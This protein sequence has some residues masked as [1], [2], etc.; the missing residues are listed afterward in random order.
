MTKGWKYESARHSLARR[1]IKSGKRKKAKLIFPQEKKEKLV[2]EFC[3]DFY[4][5][6][7]SVERA[8]NESP[9]AVIDDNLGK[10]KDEIQQI[11]EID[12]DAAI[13]SLEDM[14]KSQLF[15][16]NQN[17]LESIKDELETAN[18]EMQ[19]Y[20]SETETAM[21]AED[22]DDLED[23]L[24]TANDE[25]GNA[26]NAMERAEEI[27]KMLARFEKLPTRR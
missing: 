10:T 5:A 16:G 26:S 13:N 4:I 3:D 24:Q 6:M 25:A 27:L 11:D 2:L 20:Y 9:V 22:T 14:I 23:T 7:R 17:L 21:D 18:E 1:G 15:Y 8:Y 12:V 19:D